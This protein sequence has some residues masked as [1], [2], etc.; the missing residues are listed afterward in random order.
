MPVTGV[1]GV[2]LPN[3]DIP[4]VGY[5]TQPPLCGSKQLMRICVK[6]KFHLAVETVHLSK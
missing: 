2:C 3:A 1:K 6:N 5:S 4:V